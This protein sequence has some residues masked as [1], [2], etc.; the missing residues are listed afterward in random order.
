MAN[1]DVVKE[2]YAATASCATPTTAMGMC[3]IG[4]QANA[5]WTDYGNSTTDST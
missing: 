5:C 3:A 1:H 4:K 2:R